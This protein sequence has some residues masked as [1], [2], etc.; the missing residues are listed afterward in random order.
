MDLLESC[1]ELLDSRLITSDF[2]ATI[3]SAPSSLNVKDC[4]ELNF[5]SNTLSHLYE[6]RHDKT[7]FAASLSKSKIM[8]SMLHIRAENIDASAATNKELFLAQS[9]VPSDTFLISGIGAE[10]R[11]NRGPMIDLSSMTVNC[12]LGQ[13]DPWVKANQMAY[14]K[15]ERPSFHRKN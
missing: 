12:I 13:N 2:V 14:L 8:A 1:L 4:F 6:S 15:S 11:T 10:L 3:N 7:S 5:L 9:I